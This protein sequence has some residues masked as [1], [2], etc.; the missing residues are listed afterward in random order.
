MVWD[1]VSEPDARLKPEICAAEITVFLDN[2][3]IG[4]EAPATRFLWQC[5]DAGWIR[6][7][8]TDVT[9]TEQLDMPSEKS[10]LRYEAGQLA[11]ALTPLVLGHSRLGSSVTASEEDSERIDRV[12]RI[13]HPNADPATTRKNNVRD[14][15]TV[16]GAAR[17]GGDFLATRDG[18]IL[19]KTEPLFEELG[20]R[21]SDP[22][23]IESEVRASIRG[24]ARNRPLTGW[25]RWVPSWIPDPE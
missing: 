5:R 25:P 21:C 23:T 24:V 18:N 17:Y 6:L 10:H 9:G 11:E 14:A 4:D 2:N 7:Q 22:E 19:Q 20:I 15:M 13:L 12:F 1:G 3:I 8:L 16:A